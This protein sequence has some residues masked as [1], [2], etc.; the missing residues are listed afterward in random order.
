MYS[1]D[2]QIVSLRTPELIEDGGVSF[3]ESEIIN[4]DFLNDKMNVHYAGRHKRFLAPVYRIRG[5]FEKYFKG[6]VHLYDAVNL[7]E[8]K[9]SDDSCDS[10]RYIVIARK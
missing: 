7:T 9:D 4:L 8:I 1:E 2:R 6:G 10:T 3:Q 5:Y